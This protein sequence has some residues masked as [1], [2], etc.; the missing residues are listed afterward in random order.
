MTTYYVRHYSHTCNLGDAIQTVALCRLLPGADFLPWDWSEVPEHLAIINGWLGRPPTCN[1]R[2][3]VFAGVHLS[4]SYE[5]H[6]SFCAATKSPPVGV[7]DPA[8]AKILKGIVETTMI[9]CAT[10]TLEPY[11]GPRSGEIHIDDDSP[12]CL[13]NTIPPTMRWIDQWK[14][15][16]RLLERLR[17]ASIVYTGRLHVTLPCLAMGTPVVWRRRG[18]GAEARFSILDAIG[19]S[20]G[21][22]DRID[23]AFWRNRYINYVKNMIVASN[24]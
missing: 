8:T 22:V 13:T 9:G 16:E 14:A 23:M 24:E 20:E 3:T 17:T 7:R 18:P 1:A 21:K 15:A 12:R 10:M 4:P 2:N 5:P 19:V 11:N 6:I